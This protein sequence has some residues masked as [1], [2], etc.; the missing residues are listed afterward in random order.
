MI[1][2]ID[3]SG[4]HTEVSDDLRKYLTKKIGSLDRFA[5]KSARQSM[6]AQVILKEQTQKGA[7]E[8]VCEV[9]LQVPHESLYCSEGTVNMFAAI[10]IVEVKLKHQLARYKDLHSNPRFHR[11]L[12]VRL[13]RKPV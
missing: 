10:D 4:V 6:R 2:H 8:C 13:R 9:T 12:I 11:R 3:I 5:P 7:K 1:Q